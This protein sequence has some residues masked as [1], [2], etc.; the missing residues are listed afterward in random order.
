M[1]MKP[2]FQCFLCRRAAINHT[3]C[4]SDLAVSDGR[5]VIAAA[6]VTA[7]AGGG[8]HRFCSLHC[9]HAYC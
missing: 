2:H 6:P 3:G 5:W 4:A 1:F 7:A 8:A 9:L